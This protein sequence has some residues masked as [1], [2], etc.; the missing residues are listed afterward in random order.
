MPRRATSAFLSA[1][2]LIL[3]PLTA[4]AL[5]LSGCAQKEKPAQENP[6]VSPVEKPRE[7]FFVF[8]WINSIGNIF[9]KKSKPPTATP[10]QWAGTIRMVN[11]SERFVLI[12]SA[13]LT[14]AIPG[15]TYV[16]VSSTTETATLR[17]TNLKNPPF[18]IAD[19]LSGTPAEGERIYLPRN[20]SQT[21]PAPAP[22]PAPTPKQR[23][24]SPAATP[25]PAPSR[26]P[27]TEPSSTPVRVQVQMP[28][29]PATETAP[30]A[31]PT[32]KPKATPAPDG[33]PRPPRAIQS[34]R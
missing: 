20:S 5:L 14:S 29:A 19:I 24:S 10:P 26:P 12:E 32:P 27:Q 4:L 17:M 25:S 18:L 1:G 23:P 11:A 7:P 13:N 9:P 3:I 33:K 16:A 22:S 21:P 28:S 2:C 15:E 30:A 31:K 6:F 34:Q 8:K